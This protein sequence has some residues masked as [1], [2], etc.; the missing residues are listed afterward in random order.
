MATATAQVVVSAAPST[1]GVQTATA[2]VVVGAPSGK[3]AASAQVVVTAAGRTVSATET[4]TVTAPSTAGA[5]GF[6]LFHMRGGT[7][8]PSSVYRRVAGVW[9]LAH[10]TPGAAQPE[11][12]PV[13]DPQAPTGTPQ[14]VLADP[15]QDSF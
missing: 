8:Y 1:D 9:K 6:G 14:D 5:S 13:P 15:I 2:Q 10:A 3:V 7:V 4:V 12:A 11:P